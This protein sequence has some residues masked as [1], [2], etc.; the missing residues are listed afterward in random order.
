MDEVHEVVIHY[1]HEVGLNVNLC[2]GDNGNHDGH[3]DNY[4]DEIEEE[5][6]TLIENT[7]LK[8]MVLKTVLSLLILLIASR[9]ENW[10]ELLRKKRIYELGSLPPFLLVFA[11][12]IEPI[13]H[14]V[15]LDEGRPCPLDYLWQSYDLHRRNHPLDS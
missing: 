6:K 7:Q 1:I 8:V 14:R 12:N 9:I 4:D 3:G 15:R 11:G 5:F 13:D 10:M 2:E